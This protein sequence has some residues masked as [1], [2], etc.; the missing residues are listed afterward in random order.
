MNLNGKFKILCLLFICL[1]V[2]RA[3]SQNEVISVGAKGNSWLLHTNSSTYSIN[4]AANGVVQA[5]FYGNKSLGNATVKGILGEEVT[6]RGGYASLPTTPMLEVTFADN[7]RDID[8]V[9][10]KAEIIT[11]DGYS[12]L[13]IS[14]KDKFYP[15]TVVEYLRVIPEFDLIEKWMEVKN[16]GKKDAIKIENALSGTVFLPKNVYE[17][18][19]FPGYWGH[20][21]QQN[22]C[23]LTPGIKTI[24]V[25][26]FKSYGSSVFAV[27]Q[28]GEKSETLGKVWFGAVNYSGN[29]R[30]DFDKLASGR[31]QILG[32]LNFWDQAVNLKAGSSFTTPK[33]T[34]GYTEKGMEGVSLSLSN[35]IR[36]KLLP[37][38]HRIKTRPVL[39]NSW[40]ATTF[41]VNEEQQLVLA[42]TAKELG[43]ET[44]V[45]D[46][47]WF[48][49][50][51]NDKGGLGD[52]TIDKI[53]FPNGL[54]P[55]I[56]K[57]NGMG[58]DFGIWIEPEMV[59][60]NSDL[61]RA[62]PDWVFNYP[63]RV[64]HLGRNQLLLNLARK[65]VYDFLYKSFYTLLK[66]NNIKY[67]KWDM[68][69]ALTDPGFP[70]APIED[71]RSVRIQ[72]MENFYRL[73][74]SLRKEFPEVWFEN[75]SS[76]AGRVDLAMMSQMDFCWGSDNTDPIDRI[77]IHHSYLNAFPAN[78]MISWVTDADWH[79]Q[80]PSLEYKFDVSMAGVL[81]L[82]YDLTKW[83]DI[84]K[85]IAKQKIARYKEIRQTVQFGDHYR[86]VSPYET[87]RSIL[88][89]VN[90]SQSESIVFVY[91]LAEYPATAISDTQSASDVLLRG[92]LPDALYKI[93]GLGIYKGDYLM[94]VGFLFPLT[95]AYK[96]GIYK[97]TKQ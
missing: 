81:G 97:I 37:E 90:K 54:K 33:I 95:G 49:G 4:V 60:P 65:D 91:N 42:K 27:R 18:T 57:I 16:T 71:Q 64:R 30:L 45:I 35:F 70:S 75:C 83:G 80:K 28:A 40:Y 7:V 56:D 77:F 22:V 66:E 86:L 24:Q 89:Y 47:G 62:H 58:L 67:I 96:S 2:N 94:N 20:E 88:Q 15:L 29:W 39:Y 38:S 53:K 3:F 59:N 69:K 78:T 73:I 76:G 92:L 82:G 87:N 31:L 41:N 79:K 26:D 43:V 63:N 36:E 74:E 51:I 9:Y 6:V 17:L 13:A 8:L 12:T 61:Y 14:Q 10:D 44:F 11:I 19:H 21:F 5:T 68:N 23:L 34:F 93:E 46:D 1:L 52:W 84:E 85:N 32:G 72:Y 48:K 50:R 55:M 25:K